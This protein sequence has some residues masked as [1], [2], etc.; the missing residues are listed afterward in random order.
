MLSIGTSIRLPLGTRLRRFWKRA[1]EVVDSGAWGSC[2]DTTNRK[3]THMAVLVLG[4]GIYIGG[5]LL[6]LL[7]L[8]LVLALAFR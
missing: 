5:G 2:L 1:D 3:E 8:I 4:A 7:V 6:L